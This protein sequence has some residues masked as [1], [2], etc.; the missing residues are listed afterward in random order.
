MKELQNIEF[1]QLRKTRIKKFSNYLRK[2]YNES[3]AQ[4]KELEEKQI[5]IKQLSQIINEK[6][7]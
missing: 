7:K 4:K 3:L 1:F 6:L 2:L 5:R